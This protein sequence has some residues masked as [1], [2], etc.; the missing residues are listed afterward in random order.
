MPKQSGARTKFVAVVHPEIDGIG[1]VPEEA[2]A[3]YQALGWQRA[4]DESAVERAVT[5]P[6]WTA[7]GASDQEGEE[8]PDAADEE[9]IA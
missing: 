4:D 8:M 5:V 1:R 6:E 2:L 9:S 7:S 3:T